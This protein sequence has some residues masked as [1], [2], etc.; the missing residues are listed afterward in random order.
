MRTFLRLLTPAVFCAAAGAAGAQPA[1]TIDTATLIAAPASEWL[2]HGRDYQETRYSPLNE[3]NT[4][5]VHRL[6]LAWV[7]DLPRA[8]SNQATPLV[9]NGVMYTTAARGLVIA[10]N[11]ATGEM[12]WQWDPAIA[13]GSR[14]NGVR[15]GPNRGVALYDGK[16][17]VALLDGRLVA[18]DAETGHPV[19]SRQTTPWGVWEYNITGAPRVFNGK[20]IIGNGGAEYHGVR[21]YVTAYDAQTG[22]QV[23]RFWTVPGDP[24]LPFEHPEMEYAAATWAGEWW[25]YG[26]GGTA[27]DSF[28]YDPEANLI[29][30]GTGNGAPWSHYWRSAGEGDN[31]FLNSIVAVNADDGELVWYYQTVP[32]DDW[33]YTTTMTMTLADLVLD[34]ADRK[35]L[36]TAPKN[37][38]F[39]M[40]DRLTGELLSA[41]P[42]SEHVNWASG[43][44]LETGR[45]IENPEARY[46]TVGTW[47]APGGPAWGASNWPPTSWH[48]NTGLYYIP[49]QN[50]ASFYRLDPEYVPV[51][52]QF[53]TGTLG[54]QP[55]VDPP[56]PF[57]PPG[58]LLAWDPAAGEE[59]WRIP[60]DTQRNGGTLTAGENL[61]F[62]ARRDGW[63]YAKD[64]TTG[65]RLWEFDIGG[66]PVSPITY[67]LDGSQYV[68]ILTGPVPGGMAPARVWTFA[69]DRDSSAPE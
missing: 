60:Y 54:G 21:G 31:L 28:S 22:Q 45:P 23:W 2:T 24:S 8:G 1:S 66:V 48:P 10:M 35:V 44:D 50:N 53:S 26:G 29:Y 63:I 9:A 41:E 4:G 43:V 36:M 61:L 59:R 49:G 57:D 33:D 27:W 6:G 34:G 69:L 51:L 20:V 42:I 19:W 7:Q 3:V 15:N 37:G 58:F 46:D 64:A 67:A 65:E 56:P 12:I 62:S 30:I 47:V 25:T 40:L 38:F 13:T 52:G 55:T 17:Y 68:T 39:Y 16:V 14:G 5:N 32:A 11:A 18:L